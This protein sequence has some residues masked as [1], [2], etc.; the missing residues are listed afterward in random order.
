[1]TLTPDRRRD[2]RK[3]R[4]TRPA[5]PC[6]SQA[7]GGESEAPAGSA[8]GPTALENSGLDPSEH[9]VVGAGDGQGEIASAKDPAMSSDPMPDGSASDDSAPAPTPKLNWKAAP[10]D[11]E[12]QEALRRRVAEIDAE[13]EAWMRQKREERERAEQA[14]R[15]A[16]AAADP[17]WA[18][19]SETPSAPADPDDSSSRGIGK[20]TTRD[21]D[22]C[23]ARDVADDGDPASEPDYRITDEDRAWFAEENRKS[24]EFIAHKQNDLIERQRGV[25]GGLGSGPSDGE[26]GMGFA[27]EPPWFTPREQASRGYGTQEWGG[28]DPVEA[29][30][31][32][33]AN[34]YGHDRSTD[35]EASDAAAGLEGTS[36]VEGTSAPERAS[37]PASLGEGG[38][39]GSPEPV[40]AKASDIP[41]DSDCDAA[42]ASPLLPATAWSDLTA[43]APEMT[44]SIESLRTLVND[45]ESF[46][47]P[48]GPD[49]AVTMLDGIETLNRLTEALSVVTLSVFERVGT[50]RD[51]GA[52]STRDLV[53]NRLGVSAREASRRVDLAEQ[54]GRRV[55]VAGESLEPVHPIVADALRSGTLSSVQAEV[56]IRFLGEL[57]RKATDDQQLE[58]ERI[59]VEK[60]PLVHVRDIRI[61]FNEI[62]KWLDPDG[63]LPDESTPREDFCVNLRARKD[64][65]WDLR[66]RLDS[67]TGGI[68]H[69]LL[70]SRM[71]TDEAMQTD[72]GSRTGN[73][74]SEAGDSP[75]SDD[76]SQSD[77]ASAC[78]HAKNADDA[79][80]HGAAG[81]T[82]DVLTAGAGQQDDAVVDEA[83]RLFED[84]LRGDRYDA[85]DPTPE[86]APVGSA[87]T[88]A[89]GN[90]IPAGYGV[91]EDGTPV[92]MAS[93]QP[94]VRN[95]IYERFSTIIGRIEMG[96]VG[97][98]APFALVVTAKAEDVATGCGQ[99]TTGAAESFPISAAV[100]DGLNGAVFFHLM[101]EKGRTV[102]VQTENRY[103]NRNQ[104]TI[105][106]ARDQGCTFPGCETPPGWCDAH[107]IVPWS[108]KGRTEINNLTLA[109]SAHHHL[110]DKSDW[111]TIMLRDGRPAWV[112]P[113]TID[114]ERRPILHSRFIAGEIADT[115]FR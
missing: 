24:S 91:R 81:Q 109:C 101:S 94:S 32:G 55:T 17:E 110:I 111:H 67:V 44:G 64:G 114:P 13:Q 76:A 79:L 99:A 45:L 105:L 60:A 41:V 52:K 77:D 103:A 57:K 42:D 95:R 16:A 15:A 62:L 72:D 11:E 36:D 21:D 39:A 83:V 35:D 43:M 97:A 6:V 85:I 113:A 112:P 54:L 20:C 34:V 25:L 102:S 68:M 26:V 84:V 88:D 87:P 53:K 1:M 7:A 82:D 78:D 80:A 75:A 90:E 108:E 27:S 2:K 22:E 31:P 38:D 12:A 58:A 61:L 23:S 51:Y 56:I 48:M 86:L 10:D 9:P 14:K 29:G 3:D 47:R 4:R 59:L 65:T 5:S 46:E 28:V 73:D 50:P 98:G 96:R 71:Q 107:H 63:E 33:E 30:W 8:L 93:E 74:A 37:G 104:L 69:G 100:R 70:T 92:P 89:D 40:T 49:E 19:L 115:L 18:G 66:G 106:A